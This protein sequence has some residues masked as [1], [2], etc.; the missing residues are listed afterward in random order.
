MHAEPEPNFTN[1]CQFLP[2]FANFSQSLP[3]FGPQRKEVSAVS[4]QNGT[5]KSAAGAQRGPAT[6]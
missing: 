5:A 3:L 1:F 4:K 2:I 6:C